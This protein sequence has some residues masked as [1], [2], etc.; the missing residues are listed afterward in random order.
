MGLSLRSD[1]LATLYLA[2]PLKRIL[3]DKRAMTVP[4]LMY[5]SISNISDRVSHPYFQT[6]TDPATFRLHMEWLAGNGYRAVTLKI[7]KEELARSVR[8]NGKPFVI[9][10]DDG[11][12]DFKENAYP[13][14]KRFGF[15][16]TV[17][18]VTGHIGQELMDKECLTWREI[19]DLQ[20]EGIEFGSHTVSHPKLHGM[21]RAAIQNEISDSKTAIEDATGK[22]VSM[23]S[24]PYAF[25]QE[26]R[27]FIAELEHILRGCGYKYGVTTCIGRVNSVQAPFFLKR[28]P[29]N[30]HDDE[31]LL[32]AKLEGGYDWIQS[33]QYAFRVLKKWSHSGRQIS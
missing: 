10:F 12:R 30:L 26:D 32:Q 16:A 33:A 29:L 1:R 24:Y 14:L 5:H 7:I 8:E 4:V 21:S 6:T 27:G 17:F 20:A 25:P 19:C 15:T 18:L 23:F 22:P 28:I 2:H 9:T 11:Y 3:E 31:A 13:V